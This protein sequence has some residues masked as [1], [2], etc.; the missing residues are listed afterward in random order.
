MGKIYWGGARRRWRRLK[1]EVMKPHGQ[2]EERDETKQMRQR[3]TTDLTGARQSRAR[4]SSAI[5]DRQRGIRVRVRP[6]GE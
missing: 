5:R 2:E 3:A 6:R 4:S 1:A